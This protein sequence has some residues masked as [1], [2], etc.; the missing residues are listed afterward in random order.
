MAIGSTTPERTPMPKA[1]E[2]FNP[3]AFKGMEIIL[4]SGKFCMAIPV[5]RATAV[6]AQL[7]ATPLRKAA[8]ATP[9]GNI[10]YYNRHCKH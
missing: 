6:A 4:P 5:A 3:F 10:V 8:T 2:L 7:P 9:I 1:L